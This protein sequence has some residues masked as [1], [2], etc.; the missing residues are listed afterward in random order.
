MTKSYVEQVSSRPH[1][2]PANEG[3]DCSVMLPDLPMMFQQTRSSRPVAKLKTASGHHPTGGTL[4][5]DLSPHGSIR[6][7]VTRAYRWLML[8]S[9]LGTDRFGGKSQRR[10]ATADRFAPWWWWWWWWC[11][12]FEKLKDYSSAIQFLVLSKCN[13]EAFQMAQR[14]GHMEKYAEIIGTSHTVTMRRIINKHI[15][16]IFSKYMHKIKHFLFY[17]KL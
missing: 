12:F 1:L 5:A 6:S 8:S 14:H 13:D 10:Y 2:S 11:R 7:A 9:W 3:L 16:Y 4:E 15:L 17:Q